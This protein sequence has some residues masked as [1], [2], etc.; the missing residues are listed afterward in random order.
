MNKTNNNKVTVHTKEYKF[1]IQEMNGTVYVHRTF[2]A[3]P[4]GL[5][6]NILQPTELVFSGSPE[7]ALYIADAIRHVTGVTTPL[8][9][10]EK[11][12]TK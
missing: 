8:T 12:E 5:Y 2:V 4:N 9:P 6:G 3:D 7:E 1:D 10:E 11:V